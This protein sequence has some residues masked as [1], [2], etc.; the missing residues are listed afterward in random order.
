MYSVEEHHDDFSLRG[1]N[2]LIDNRHLNVT[3]PNNH[4]SQQIRK[5][6]VAEEDNSL[7]TTSHS[8]SSIS[9][10]SQKTGDFFIFLLQSQASAMQFANRWSNWR[11]A[12][13]LWQI[14]NYSQTL[15]PFQFT[16]SI[17][18]KWVCFYDSSVSFIWN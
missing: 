11:I 13:F 9:L 14:T 15:W 7:L 5:S 16:N 12:R 3:I 1:P 8:N 18:Y 4:F 2:D 6:D 10:H 17:W